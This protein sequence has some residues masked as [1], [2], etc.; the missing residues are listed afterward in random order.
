MRL[1]TIFVSIVASLVAFLGSSA[2]TAQVGQTP[3]VPT[4]VSGRVFATDTGNPLANA[5]VTL[6]GPNEFHAVA[7]TRI[8][9]G[10]FAFASVPAGVYRLAAVKPGYVRAE[11]GASGFG[12]AGALRVNGRPLSDI[13]I[14]LARGGAVSGRVLDSRGD[15]LMGQT[16]TAAWGGDDDGRGA[17]AITATRTDDLG[18]YRL[19][20]LPG[21]MIRVHLGGLP[22]RGLPPDRPIGRSVEPWLVTLDTG[23]ERSAVDFVLPQSQNLPVRYAAGQSRIGIAIRGRIAG[24]DGRPLP[25]ALV[26]LL[27]LNDVPVSRMDVGDFIDLSNTSGRPLKTTFTDEVG[28]Y[29]LSGISPGRYRV[30]ARTYGYVPMGFDQPRSSASGRS[31]TINDSDGPDGVDIILPR[32]GAITG[33]IADDIGNPI[34]GAIVSIVEA[35]FENGRRVLVQTPVGIRPSDDRGQYRVFGIEPGRYFVR[36]GAGDPGG[37][38]FG[39]ATGSE[40]PGYAPSFFPGTTVAAQAVPVDVGPSSTVTGVDFPLLRTT[41][42]TVSGRLF[43][44]D[45]QTFHGRLWY[46]PDRRER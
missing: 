7:L 8:D 38:R 18:D 26:M 14:R 21:G 2:F 25:G 17:T 36:A 24:D 20:G 42:A 43:T 5:R 39:V 11:F 16:V 32:L 33:R 4:I 13:Q 3:A 12:A 22:L 28:R 30:G 35:R 31:I 37:L 45:N 34:E 15:P 19:G 1:T 9:D 40:I 44:S 29:E 27:P 6:T 46:R 41:M 10:G 23:E